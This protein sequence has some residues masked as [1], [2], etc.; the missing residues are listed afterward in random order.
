MFCQK[1]GNPFNEGAAFCPKCGAKT[2]ATSGIRVQGIGENNN[3]P[4]KP[5][6]KKS[7]LLMCIGVFLYGLYSFL[8]A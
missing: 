1:C 4:I 7:E 8:M 2:D 6:R 3:K 5:K